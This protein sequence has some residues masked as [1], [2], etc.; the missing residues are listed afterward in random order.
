MLNVVC[1]DIAT[2]EV[3]LLLLLLLL[4][5]GAAYACPVHSKLP[6][7]MPATTKKLMNM[8]ANGACFISGNSVVPR[9]WISLTRSSRQKVDQQSASTMHNT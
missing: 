1:M 9:C 8:F 3:L 5:L 2:D 6:F 7:P 4:L